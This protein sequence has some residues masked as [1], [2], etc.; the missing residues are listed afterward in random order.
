MF[1]SEGVCCGHTLY[2]PRS[3]SRSLPGPVPFYISSG[4]LVTLSLS[5]IN[6]TGGS[7]IGIWTQPKLVALSL[8]VLVLALA[9]AVYLVGTPLAKIR[10]LAVVRSLAVPT[11]LAGTYVL[12][13][14]LSGVLS[15]YPLRGLWGQGDGASWWLSVF[16][17][18]VLS[19][20]VISFVPQIW[21]WVL[22]GFLLG[23]FL[24]AAGVILQAFDWTLDF[25]RTS[26][27]LSPGNPNQL[28]SSI[29]RGQMPVGLTLHRGHA[30]IV[31][32]LAGLSVAYVRV[33][34]GRWFAGFAFLQVSILTALWLTGTR[35][36]WAAFLIGMGLLLAQLFRVQEKR[37]LLIEQLLLILS[38][39]G[40]ALVLVIGAD[41]TQRVTPSLGTSVDRF[42]SGRLSLW[43]EAADFI[44][45]R[46]IIGWG[47]GGFGTAYA[48][49][50]AE[51]MGVPLDSLRLF[52]Y[53]FAYTDASGAEQAVL[54]PTN[55]AHNIVLDQLV[56]YGVVG[57]TLYMALWLSLLYRVWNSAYRVWIGI[58]V[59]YGSFLFTW[60]DAV[61]F[62]HV[63]WLLG[64]ILM[65]LAIGRQ[66]PANLSQ[67]V[68]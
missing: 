36:P 32:A 10:L 30:G 1:V 57:L 56:A 58:L 49:S 35:A 31:L 65:G 46:P 28:V 64:G 68:D 8:L 51:S 61:G 22:A 52:D 66:I 67:A 44:A 60:Y 5:A 12:I 34:F 62:G 25:T 24:M 47:A 11:C 41:A 42:S 33:L 16:A 19:A 54:L 20:L 45:R 29:F 43:A 48:V 15:P 17:L 55:K 63:P 6:P 3:M 14:Y 53:S 40:L 7:R 4:V 23:A 39:I 59:A 27:Q 37:R 38:S 21:R 13:T 9:V 2:P 26:G 18:F 50:T